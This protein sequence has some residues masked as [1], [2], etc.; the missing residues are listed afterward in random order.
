MTGMERIAGGV[1]FTQGV[2]LVSPEIK[3]CVV[4]TQLRSL[5]VESTGQV[6]E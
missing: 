1:V 2:E 4:T 3:C 5:C 6:C